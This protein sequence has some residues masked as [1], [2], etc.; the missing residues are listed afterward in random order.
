MEVELQ[1]FHR[2][3]AGVSFWDWLRLPLFHEVARQLG[4]QEKTQ[5]QPN[6]SPTGYLRSLPSILASLLFKNLFALPEAE[7]LFIGHP[8]RQR[9]KGLWWDIYCDPIIEDVV[10]P[11]GLS[12]L[13][14]ERPYLNRHRTPARTKNLRYL[15]GIALRSALA[16]RWRPLGLNGEDTR[17]LTEIQEYLKDRFCVSAD[18]RGL[19]SHQLHLRQSQISL[20]RRLL[21]RVRPRL[22]FLVV[23]YGN[24][25]I[26]EACRSLGI[27]TVELQ[28]GLLAPM[29]LGYSFPDAN[30][31]KK[32]FPD[33]FFAFGDFWKETVALPLVEDRIFSV[34]FPHFERELSRYSNE[35]KR[36]QIVFLSQKSIGA[37]LSRCATRLAARRDLGYGII[38]KL[39]PG[40]FRHWR[41]DYPWLAE[42]PIEVIDGDHP[43][44][45][46]LLSGSSIQ[47]GVYSTAIYEGLAFGLQ[48]YLLPL[49]GI[50]FMGGLVE[51]VPEVMVVKGADD[52]AEKIRDSRSLLPRNTHRFFRPNAV[53]NIR[54]AIQAILV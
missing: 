6:W 41:R 36:R 35:P 8:R 20:Y 27:P 17:V 22:V 25:T 29:H 44:L 2:N 16:R 30:H 32:N 13:L 4:F 21:Q 26:I 43:T 38:Y 34:G 3:L 46:Q 47:V 15:D 49:S 48:T 19:C 5:D 45:Y 18:V 23:S 24:E 9:R 11:S 7:L 52:L 37:E 51:R 10:E 53:E 42:V 12:Y 28:H 39:H 33:Y 40:E 14:V 1:L 54:E 31:R 50:E